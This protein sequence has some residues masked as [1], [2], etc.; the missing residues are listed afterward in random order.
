MIFGPPH[1]G[2]GGLPHHKARGGDP[3][4]PAATGQEAVAELPRLGEFLPAI[5]TGGGTDLATAYRCPARRGGLDM[6]T[7]DESQFWPH[8][9]D[10]LVCG[11]PHTPGSSCRPVLSRRRQQHSR[12]SGSST[13]VRIYL[14]TS[15]LEVK[16]LNTLLLTESYWQLFRASATSDTC[17]M[18]GVSTSS[19]TISH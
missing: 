13:A 12:G 9:G 1:H 10:S 11:Y 15:G 19:P 5:H 14:E 17:W 4:L 6:D 7:G 18:G 8:Q 3:E 16:Q 2:G